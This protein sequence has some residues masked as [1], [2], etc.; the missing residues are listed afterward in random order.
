VLEAAADAGAAADHQAVGEPSRGAGAGQV[1]GI[2]AE[3]ANDDVREVCQ[4]GIEHL[5]ILG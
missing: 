1:R 3:V 5:D 2:D 4:R